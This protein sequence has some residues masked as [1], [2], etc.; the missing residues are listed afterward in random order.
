MTNAC[1]TSCTVDANCIASTYCAAK[2]CVPRQVNGKPCTAIDQCASNLCV[3][4]VCCNTPCA[5]GCDNCNIPNSVGSCTPVIKGS[6]GSPS[7]APYLCNGGANC[8]SACTVNADCAPGYGCSQK[9]TCLLINGSPCVDPTLCQSLLCV[10]GV[11]C[12]QAC[13]GQ[14]N[15]CNLKGFA[16]SCQTV[17]GPP[18]GNRTPCAG[19]G[20]PCAGA[21]N[22]NDPT[23]CYFPG[24]NTTCKAATCVNNQYTPAE[25]CDGSG[26]CAPLNSSNCFPYVCGAMACLSNCM[27]DTDCQSGRYCSAV[28]NNTCVPTLDPGLTCTRN[29]QCTL[30]FCVDGVCC[31]SAC[32]GQCA[33]CNRM[34]FPGKC[35]AIIG[36]PFNG[37]PAC[38]SDGSAC[39]GACDG[40]SYTACKYPTGNTCNPAACANGNALAASVCNGGGACPA[41]ATT[42]C[43]PYTCVN[44]ACLS[45]CAVDADCMQGATCVMKQCVGKFGLGVAC[46]GGNQCQT[47]FCADGV[48]CNGPCTGQCAACNTNGAP[49]QCKAVSGMPVG[50]RVACGGDGSQCTGA[51]DGMNQSSC[52]FPTN[53]LTC[54]MPSCANGVASQAAQCDGKG[55]C[56]AQTTMSCAPF[57]CNGNACGGGCLKDTDCV[58]GDYCSMNQCLPKATAGMPCAAANQCQT[59]FCADGVCCNTACTDQCAACNTLNLSGTCVPVA[60]PPVGLRMPCAGAGPCKAVCDGMMTI[61]CAFPSAMTICAPAGCNN[62]IA[63]TPSTCDGAGA[64][65]PGMTMNCPFGCSGVT[66][67]PMFQPDMAMISPPDLAMTPPPDLATVPDLTIT[68]DLTT[69][70]DQAVTPDLLTTSDL[71]PQGDLSTMT[72]LATVP[73]DLNTLRDQSSPSDMALSSDLANVPATDFASASDGATGTPAPPAGCGCHVGTPPASR[74]ASILFA[75]MLFAWTLRT[76]KR[77]NRSAPPLLR[78]PRS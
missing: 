1:P 47:G 24:N 75:A 35:Q 63:V 62:G 20:T 60:G 45:A 38:A 69:A 56:P 13:N 76:R 7:C 36:P 3:D 55:S 15:S 72:D 8:P 32:A 21:C 26:G 70:P 12:G 65:N 52:A 73:A 58:L 49:G 27:A 17:T 28:N 6:A 14:C 50:G 41:Q 64:C 54:K 16:G 11:C 59:G 2:Q 43:A 4:S 10:D 19:T 44:N 66:C 53:N 78:V 33:S 30:G 71:A 48:C 67:A 68:P 39:G 37:R 51:C 18:A 57:V 22:G 74:A 29:A 34:P 42:N 25:H 9:G 61:A 46:A 23:Q 77:K 40:N 31:E 5:G